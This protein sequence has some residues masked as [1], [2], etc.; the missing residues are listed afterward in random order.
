MKIVGIIM[1]AL[2]FVALFIC[3]LRD[4]GLRDTLIAIGIALF[5]VLWLILGIT[6]MTGGK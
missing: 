3:A 1:V 6:L 2:P 4:I 5:S